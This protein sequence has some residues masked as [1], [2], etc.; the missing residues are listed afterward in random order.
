[1]YHLLQQFCLHRVFMCSVQFSKYAG[2]I[3]LND[4]SWCVCCHGDEA[5]PVRYKPICIYC[6]DEFQAS[7]TRVEAG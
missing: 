7:V 1:M 3:S 5:F 6:S 4:S 2:V